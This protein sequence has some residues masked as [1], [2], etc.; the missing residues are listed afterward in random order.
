MVVDCLSFRDFE[1]MRGCLSLVI[2]GCMCLATEILRT[3]HSQTEQGVV[4]LFF[5]LT[6]VVTPFR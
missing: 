5:T 6:N 4:G 2:Y 1:V 3:I